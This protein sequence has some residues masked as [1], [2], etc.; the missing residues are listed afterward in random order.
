MFDLRLRG[1]PTSLPRPLADRA[2]YP[3]RFAFA[4]QVARNGVVQGLGLG[5]VVV[6]GLGLLAWPLVLARC[7]C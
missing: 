6:V 2:E 5:M 1:G 4:I 3:H 7:P